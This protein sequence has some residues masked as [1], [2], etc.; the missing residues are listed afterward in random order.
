MNSVSAI[1]L[2]GGSG[3]SLLRSQFGMPVCLL[4]TPDAPSLVAAWV[5]LVKQLDQVTDITV[6]T[7]RPEDLPKIEEQLGSIPNFLG[8]PLEV[9]TDK[10]EH[11]GTAGTL[12]DTI[13]E[14]DGENDILVIEG[15]TIPPRNIQVVSDVRIDGDDVDGAIIKTPQSEPAG[16]IILKKRVLELVPEVGFF[17]L[18]EQ[19]IPKVISDGNRVVVQQIE[20][21]LRRITTVED[22]LDHMADFSGQGASRGELEPSIHETAQ[23]DP[24]AVLTSSVLVC[25]GVQVGPGAIIDQAVLLEGSQIG[26]NALVTRSIVKPN[27]QI[28]AGSRFDLSEERLPDVRWNNRNGGKRTNVRQDPGFAGRSR[29]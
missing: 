13:L 8:Y 4:P 3:P 22:Y 6:V 17:D 9:T 10:N 20:D 12:R 15:T 23:I 29:T 5:E 28:Q 14:R 26:A 7:G 2:V 24:T 25:K 1:I 16:M 27:T 18:K 11:R 19:L 21:R